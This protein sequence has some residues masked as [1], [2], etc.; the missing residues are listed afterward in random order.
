MSTN[1]TIVDPNIVGYTT[2]Q[3]EF[4]I[5]LKFLRNRVGASFTYWNGDDR[6]FVTTLTI[7]GASGYTGYRTNAGLITKRGY[8]IQLNGRPV[9][10]K[11]LKIEINANLGILDD[12]TVK[13]IAEGIDQ[14]TAIDARWGTTGP[15]MI[16]RVGE[17]W[18]QIYGNGMKRINGQPVLDG[19]GFYVNDPTTFFGSALPEHTG[20][21]QLS[22]EFKRI[23]LSANADFQV[24]GKFFSLSDQ[25]GSY[26]GLT[27]RTAT[28]NDK[29]NPI[30]DKV[31]DGG[32]IHVFGVDDTGHPVD[33]YVEADD[34]FHNIYSNKTFD[35]YVYDLTFV[36]LREVSLGYELPIKKWGVNF[37][38]KAVLSI[39][40]RNPWL[41]YAKTADFDPSEIANLSGESGNMPGTRSLGVNLKIGF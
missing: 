11:D 10:N 2:Q 24:G 18:G 13:E 6:D 33:Y 27:A 34:Y 7:N 4:G 21:A 3:Q 14:T 39:V 29:G 30:R 9:W 38:N 41:I 31:A 23:I 32:G 40:A 25:W 28:I 37:M 5:D 19:D 1:G 20:G 22:V 17:R 36:K 12:N 15:Y 16:H 26:S 8:N 35:P